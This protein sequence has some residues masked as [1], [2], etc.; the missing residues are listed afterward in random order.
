[1]TQ[2]TTPTARSAGR[3]DI[4]SALLAVAALMLLVGVVFVSLRNVDQTRSQ[5]RAGSPFTYLE[6]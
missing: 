1:M 5:G 6:K 2:L 4:Y 3:P